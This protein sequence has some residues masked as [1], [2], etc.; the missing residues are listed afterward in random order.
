MNSGFPRSAR[1]LKQ[2]QFERILKRSNPA[3]AGE[4]SFRKSRGPLLMT[5]RSNNL[6]EAPQ[7]PM[8]ARLGVVAA[9]RWLPRAVDRNQFKR[10]AREA[11]RRERTR[12]PPVDL[13]LMMQG[14]MKAVNRDDFDHDLQRLF[15]QLRAAH[16][17]TLEKS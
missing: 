3:A 9:R 17:Q 7:G 14:Q 2:A 11:F 10:W 16:A 8:G 13:I 6:V 4:F 12:L 1:L 5:A 15:E